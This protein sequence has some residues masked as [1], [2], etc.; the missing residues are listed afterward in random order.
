MGRFAD[1]LHRARREQVAGCDEPVLVVGEVEGAPAGALSVGVSELPDLAAAGSR[2]ATI[3]TMDALSGD[4][5]ATRIAG[6][7]VSLLTDDGRVRF[8]ERDRG[9]GTLRRLVNRA[10]GDRVDVT[11]A[12]WA[13]GATV[14]VL[15]RPMGPLGP[16]YACG[17]ARR[18]LTRPMMPRS[19]EDAEEATT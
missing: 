1:Q 2:F 13:G 4:G 3:L 16:A 8:V 19:T 5:G 18:S 11:G 10:R 12:L 17:V 9:R 15:T 14:I 7:L 6:Q